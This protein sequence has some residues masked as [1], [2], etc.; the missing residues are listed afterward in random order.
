MF[1]LRKLIASCL[2]WSFKLLWFL[3]ILNGAF[4]TKDKAE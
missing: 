1:S 3:Y 2:F 4:N